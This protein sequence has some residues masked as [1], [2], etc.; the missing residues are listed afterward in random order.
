MVAFVRLVPGAD[1]SDAV[2]LR[3]VSLDQVGKRQRAGM[4]A[5]ARSHSDADN[6]RESEPVGQVVEILQAE[7]QVGFLI[8]DCAAGNEV[9]VTQIL[10]CLFQLDDCEERLRRRAEKLF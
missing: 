4:P 6:K 2:G 7:H 10:F 8:A 3:A 1:H 5:H 9:V